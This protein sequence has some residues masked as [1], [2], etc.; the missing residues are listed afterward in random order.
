MINRLINQKTKIKQNKK[1]NK[2]ASF[3]ID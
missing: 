2:S 3:L 1:N